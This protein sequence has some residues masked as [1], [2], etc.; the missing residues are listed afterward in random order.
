MRAPG[1]LTSYY[2]E[3]ARPHLVAWTRDTWSRIHQENH[4][5]GSSHLQLRKS[6]GQSVLPGHARSHP[7][8]C[9]QGGDSNGSLHVLPVYS[10]QAADWPRATVL[11][12][13]QDMPVAGPL[14][15]K[16][17]SMNEDVLRND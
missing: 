11:P 15:G 2:Q 16:Y 8:R 4:K 17:Q 12:V 13:A 6:W 7:W 1:R 9:P 3:F 14:P 5:S 10:R